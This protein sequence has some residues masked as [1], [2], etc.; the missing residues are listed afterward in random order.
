MIAMIVGPED[1]RNGPIPV[2]LAHAGIAVR[3]TFTTDQAQSTLDAHGAEH[4]VLVLDADALDARAGSSTWAA[5]LDTNGRVPAVIVARGRVDAAARSRARAHRI[6]LEDPFDAA[7]VVAAVR[8][9]SS[10]RPR[11]LRRPAPE[12]RG[13]G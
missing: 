12:L 11:P 13:T 1:M 6:P 8:R 3:G 5:F 10:A 9:V 7:A 2:A 4:C